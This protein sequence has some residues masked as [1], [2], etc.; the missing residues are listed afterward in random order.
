MKLL[1]K[2]LLLILL[3]SGM[4]A[5][6]QDEVVITINPEICACLCRHQDDSASRVSL[7][8]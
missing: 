8:I 6:N 1:S 3:A 5:C 2:A 7:K 4:S